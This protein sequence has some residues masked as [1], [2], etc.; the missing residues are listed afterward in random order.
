LI[1]A[2]NT[3]RWV[4][5]AVSVS[6]SDGGRIELRREPDGV[7]VDRADPVMWFAK[8]SLDMIKAE[9]FDDGWTFDGTHVTLDVAN[10]RWVWKLTG[11]SKHYE[12]GPGLTP[13]LLVE[14]VWPD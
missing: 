10:G 11:R 4:I 5:G 3:G 8:H 6:G 1:R 12:Y 14:A 9:P 2:V 13:L 7:Y